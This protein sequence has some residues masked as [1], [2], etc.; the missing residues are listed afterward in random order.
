MSLLQHSLILL[1]LIGFC[2]FLSLSEISLAA[3]RKLKLKLLAE[4]G[5]TKA[6]AVLRLQDQPAH[7]FAASQIGLNAVAILGGILGEAAFTPFFKSL[8][9]LFY[10]GPWLESLS[11]ALSFTLVTLLFILFADLMPKRLA[12][13]SPERIAMLVIT[14]LQWF[15]KLCRPLAFIINGLTNLMFRLF[16]IE[17]I[18]NDQLT[19]DDISAMVDAGAQAGVLQ[20]QEH[21]VIENVFELESRTVTSSMTP[22]ESVVYFTLQENEAEIK[23][24][25]AAYP[26]SKFMVCDDVIDRVVG[27]VDTKD[28]LVRLLNGQSLLRLHE[29]T[30]RTVLMV[31]DTLTL[32]EMLDRFRAQRDSFAVVINEYALVVGL[33]TL[34]DVMSTVMGDWISVIPEEQQ[35]VKRDDHSWLIDGSTPVQDV[36]RALELDALPDE[37]N[38]ETA[39]GFIMY[40]LRKIPKRT[41]MVRHA[42]YQFEVVDIDH[43][44]I[45]QLLV[46]RTTESAT[47]PLE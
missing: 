1:T 28:L 6:E 15:V 14:P 45:D 12:M 7:F 13:T 10:Q 18:R 44:K 36:K 30:I 42:G 3:A 23:S 20:Q 16:K 21:H 8:L 2:A 22:R 38:Y 11:F 47:L 43:Y 35:I 37:E 39:A 5:N 17:T 27:Y 24:K 25:L 19:F 41:D 34:D 46:T 4:A 32:S 40:M 26:H 29:S 31:P 33:I 9:I